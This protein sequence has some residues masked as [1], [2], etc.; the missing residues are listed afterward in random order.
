MKRRAALLLSIAPFVARG[1]GANGDIYLSKTEGGLPVY[2]SEP[3][4]RETRLYLTVAPPARPQQ[5]RLASPLIQPR[6]SVA[7]LYEP[8]FGPGG[9][10]SIAQLTAAAAQA[11][12]VPQALLLATMHAESAFNP[13][14]RSPA[15]AIGLMQIIPAT[16]RRYGVEHNLIEPSNN[17]DVGARYLRD[18]LDLFNGSKE[19]ALAAYNAGEGAVIKY[20]RQIPPYAETRAYV[21]KVLRLFVQYRERLLPVPDS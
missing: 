8:R 11:Y 15:G 4:G 9:G 3:V 5:M 20:G 7:G 6:R 14:A 12:G 13:N 18:L 1:V 21:P 2:S 19:L 16:G 10:S 17:I